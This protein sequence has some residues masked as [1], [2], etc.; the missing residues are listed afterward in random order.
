MV[1]PPLVFVPQTRTRDGQAQVALQAARRLAL[2]LVLGEWALERLER[3]LALVSG[4]ELRKDS[5]GIEL[6]GR[7]AEL[8]LSGLGIEQ[9]GGDVA[10]AAQIPVNGAC[11]V[12][13]LRDGGDDALGSRDNVARGKDARFARHVVA[14]DHA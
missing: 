8:L 4:H 13:A 10:V 1:P 2:S 12:A 5:L 7:L 3:E 9:L 14:I 11:R 6:L